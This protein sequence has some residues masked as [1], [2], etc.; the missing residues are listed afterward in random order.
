MSSI[1]GIYIQMSQG[2][3]DFHCAPPPNPNPFLGIPP[4]PLPR[5]NRSV[6]FLLEYGMAFSKMFRQQEAPI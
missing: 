6:A 2:K 3:K 1:V 4:L 5:V